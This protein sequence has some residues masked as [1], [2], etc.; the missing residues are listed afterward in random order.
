MLEEYRIGVSNF[1]NRPTIFEVFRKEENFFSIL[2]R[3]PD[4][5]TNRI[6]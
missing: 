6:C 2:E 1:E 5:L 4:A 3:T